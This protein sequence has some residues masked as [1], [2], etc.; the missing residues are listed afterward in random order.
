M[1]DENESIRLNGIISMGFVCDRLDG[2]LLQ[3]VSAR[4]LEKHAL[5]AELPLAKTAMEQYLKKFKKP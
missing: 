1:F 4:A 5:F 3:Y 2:L